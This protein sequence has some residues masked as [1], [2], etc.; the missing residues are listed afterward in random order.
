MVTFDA[1][2]LDNA[3]SEDGVVH[4][5]VAETSYDNESELAIG[6]SVDDPLY[7]SSLNGFWPCQD[8]V[9]PLNDFAGS[10]D[11]T[12][13]GASLEVSGL[14]GRN[15]LS[16]DGTDDLVDVGSGPTLT[17]ASLTIAFWFR[18]RSFSTNNPRLISKR[19]SSGTSYEINIRTAD[20]TP[21][22]LKVS[23]NGG[24]GKVDLNTSSTVVADEW[25]HAAV[26]YDQSTIRAYLDG[27]PVGDINESGDVD[28]DGAT[29]RFGVGPAFFGSRG[30]FD[31]KLTDVRLYSRALSGS[32][33]QDLYDVAAVTSTLTTQSK[34]V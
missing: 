15:S 24:G 7:G 34:P 32:E 28:I 31:G 14:F 17:P 11:G 22:F 20:G 10:N 8:S 4:E 19:D 25:Q 33:V 16:F 9:A 1:A 3:S 23:L 6:Y 13:D 18:P 21:Y 29:L 12:I 5:S 2:D 27:S 26:T 30:W